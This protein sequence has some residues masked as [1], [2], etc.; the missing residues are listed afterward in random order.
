VAFYVKHS[1]KVDNDQQS[2]E[3]YAN[4]ID[5]SRELLLSPLWA[6]CQTPFGYLLAINS[7]SFYQ[8]A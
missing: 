5:F 2:F 8:S 4:H 1:K 7:R 6:V 3:N